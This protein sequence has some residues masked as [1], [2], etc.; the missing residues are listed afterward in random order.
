[1]GCFALQFGTLNCSACGFIQL[2]N[3]TVG[4]LIIYFLFSLADFSAKNVF[5]VNFIPLP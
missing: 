3:T 4:M 5:S 1:M 2:G